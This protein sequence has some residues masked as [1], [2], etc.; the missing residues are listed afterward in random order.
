[1][2]VLGGVDFGW[3]L[4][5][6]MQVKIDGAVGVYDDDVSIYYLQKMSTRCECLG[7]IKQ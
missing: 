6:S 4:L 5:L 7:D 1:M 2:P 3:T